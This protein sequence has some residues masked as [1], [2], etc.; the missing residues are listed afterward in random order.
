MSA[1][2]H[3][4]SQ[5]GKNSSYLI[6]FGTGFWGSTRMV[7]A[8]GTRLQPARTRPGT[9][10]GAEI[11]RTKRMVAPLLCASA[12]G[13][14]DLADACE[15]ST[16][17]ALSPAS[18][19]ILFLIVH[20]PFP[21]FIKGTKWINN[22]LEPLMDLREAEALDDSTSGVEKTMNTS[23]G[24]A[25]PT[26]PRPL[27]LAIVI[28]LSVTALLEI[29][30]WIAIATYALA[31]DGVNDG[32]SDFGRAWRALVVAITWLYAATI[33]LTRP[34]ATSN[35][36]LFS[37]Y[38]VHLLGSALVV[39]G[40]VL[41]YIDGLVP[42]SSILPVIVA[43]A[44]NAAILV[45][46]V[47]VQLSRPLDY[48]R[49]GKEKAE[50]GKSISPGDYTILWGWASFSW[51]SRAYGSAQSIARRK[52][53]LVHASFLRSTYCGGHKYNTERE[54]CV[55]YERDYARTTRL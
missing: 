34:S 13:P 23:T 50:I 4:I 1:C 47:L 37:L 19:V 52:C 30:S 49:S 42:K 9:K 41:D 39:G 3:P 45:G 7:R 35:Y 18:L 29:G 16:W 33:P 14:F 5:F 21:S 54:G 24:I 48:P 26:T 43:Q 11:E 36:R 27:R 44:L 51:E 32:A 8:T 53:L 22:P 12:S 25:E 40:E 46:L 15:R 2:D 28:V 38:L 20:L 55:A 31:I 17:A 6:W 10:A